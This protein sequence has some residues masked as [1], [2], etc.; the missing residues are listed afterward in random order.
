MISITTLPVA[1]SLSVPTCWRFTLLAH[2]LRSCNKLNA[3][4]M[5]LDDTM[6]A[7]KELLKSDATNV[8]YKV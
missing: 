7:E 5:A 8:V 1:A 6:L 2:L 4:L 3:I